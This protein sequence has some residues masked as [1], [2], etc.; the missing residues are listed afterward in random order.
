MKKALILLFS[1]MI[2]GCFIMSK[3]YKIDMMCVAD[4]CDKECVKIGAQGGM[5]LDNI[6]KTKKY[7]YYSCMCLG[8]GMAREYKFDFSKCQIK[9]E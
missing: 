5:I 2:S 4:I 6:D 9:E 1:L 8:N 3:N 7:N